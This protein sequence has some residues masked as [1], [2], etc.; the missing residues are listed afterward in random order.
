LYSLITDPKAIVGYI[1]ISL[2]LSLRIGAKIQKVFI[3]KISTELSKRKI[4]TESSPVLES[5]NLS[6]IWFLY[7]FK[8]KLTLYHE[9]KNKLNA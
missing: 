9:H 6:F 1:K 3:C 4:L 8:D 7:S 2:Y 5:Q